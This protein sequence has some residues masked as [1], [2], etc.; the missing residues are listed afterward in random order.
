MLI[1]FSIFYSILMVMAE[2]P[3]DE[4]ISKII[5]N[6]GLVNDEG[7]P[8]AAGKHLNFFGIG[9][10]PTAAPI[11]IKEDYVPK[12]LYGEYIGYD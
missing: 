5:L 12:P 4:D 7:R 2:F 9:D 8:S 6:P 10:E 1:V 3:S 11:K